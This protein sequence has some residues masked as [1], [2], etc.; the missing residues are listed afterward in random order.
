[1]H[2]VLSYDIH[3]TGEPRTRIENLIQDTIK[4]YS[5]VKPLTTLY[6]MEVNDQS[7]WDSILKSITSIYE[8]NKGSI[9]FIMTPLMQGGHYNG[10][11][12]Q[13]LWEEINKRTK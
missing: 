7:Q 9:N 4:Q 13:K 1:M 5:W 6:V 3:L 12:N 2:F 11:L 8:N 10:I